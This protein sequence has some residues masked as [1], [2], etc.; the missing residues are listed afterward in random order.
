MFTVIVKRLKNNHFHFSNHSSKLLGK[1]KVGIK[2]RN[3]N[4]LPTQSI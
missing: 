1:N 3:T 2:T 4:N